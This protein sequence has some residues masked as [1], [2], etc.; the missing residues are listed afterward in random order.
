MSVTVNIPSLFVSNI[1]GY[2]V[3]CFEGGT[4]CSFTGSQLLIQY[5]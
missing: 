3:Q 5:F 2:G 1:M 4:S